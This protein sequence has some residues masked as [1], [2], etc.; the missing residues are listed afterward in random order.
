[1]AAGETCTN[2]PDYV[3]FYKTAASW[4]HRCWPKIMTTI[5]RRCVWT[6]MI[7][8]RFDWGIRASS[9]RVTSFWL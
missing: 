3:W 5:W 2:R 4:R 7:L 9:R 1:M 8:L 6:P